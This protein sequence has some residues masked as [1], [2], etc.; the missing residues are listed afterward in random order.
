MTRCACP[1]EIIPISFE[2]GAT[3]LA[4]ITEGP[5]TWPSLKTDV[6]ATIAI[7]AVHLEIVGLAMDEGPGA[8]SGPVVVLYADGQRQASRA[9]GMRAIWCWGPAFATGSPPAWHIPGPKLTGG[10]RGEC[11]LPVLMRARTLRLWTSSTNSPS[12]TVSGSVFYRPP[13]GGV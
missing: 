8:R 10:Y 7:E 12:L 6:D 9:G 11:R 5:A 13:A 1:P 2:L 4:T 3:E